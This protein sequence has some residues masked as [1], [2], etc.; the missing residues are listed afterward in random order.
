[1]RCKR[2]TGV[3]TGR[4]ILRG[5]NVVLVYVPVCIVGVESKCCTYICTDRDNLRGVSIVL[6]FVQVG[7]VGEE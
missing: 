1:M 7:R 6:V 2:C 4:Y 5:V 3:Y